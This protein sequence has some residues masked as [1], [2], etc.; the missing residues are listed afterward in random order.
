MIT[1][2]NKRNPKKKGK[3]E[4][5]VQVIGVKGYNYEKDGVR[6]SGK[7]LICTTI[8]AE[9]TDDGKGNFKY[10]HIA[11]EEIFVPDRLEITKEQL[12]E[13]IGRVVDI[14]QEKNLGD[15]YER[16]TAIVPV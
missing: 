1:V 16:M 6:K 7:M 14:I 9:E 4:M 11:C 2:F 10:G 15:R 5:K 8:T 3:R 12:I 13:M